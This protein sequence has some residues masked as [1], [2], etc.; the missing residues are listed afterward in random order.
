MSREPGDKASFIERID[1]LLSPKRSTASSADCI[2]PDKT[3]TKQKQEA[4]APQPSI[5][6]TCGRAADS[7][8][9]HR[10]KR[11]LLPSII[12][13]LAQTLFELP[14]GC[15]CARRSAGSCCSGRDSGAL[16][17]KRQKR[18]LRPIPSL[19]HRLNESAL[20]HAVRASIEFLH[21][22]VL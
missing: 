19:L 13:R 18:L 21:V 8:T 17:K 16:R 5:V 12:L 7:I 11:R 1:L 4:K 14:A 10:P 15:T 20:L 2:R 9:A 6:W 22:F 3:K